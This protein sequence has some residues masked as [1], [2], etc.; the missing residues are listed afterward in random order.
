MKGKIS[1]LLF[2]LLF[3]IN[4]LVLF[5]ISK[6]NCKVLLCVIVSVPVFVFSQKS[7]AI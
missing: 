5:K 2:S 1:K 6:H 4:L 3:F 7:R